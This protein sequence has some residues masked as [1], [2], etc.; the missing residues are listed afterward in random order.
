M[1]DWASVENYLI[2]ALIAAIGSVG[3]VILETAVGAVESG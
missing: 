1:C 2:G 3:L